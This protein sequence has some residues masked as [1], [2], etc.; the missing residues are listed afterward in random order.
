[1]FLSESVMIERALVPAADRYDT[2]PATDIFNMALYGHIA[3]V[4][5]H[6]AGATGTVKIQV[7][8]CSDATGTGNTAIAFRYRL[9]STVPGTWGAITSSAS[10]GYTTTAGADQ[11]VIVELDSRELSTT[12][13]FV[14]LQLTEVANSPV[15][16]AVYALLSEARYKQ[17]TLNDATV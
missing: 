3:F 6:G 11:M 14:R 2:N 16:A 4:L 1:M 10:T 15:S 9:K 7:E 13:K 17:N 12:K 5:D 8:E